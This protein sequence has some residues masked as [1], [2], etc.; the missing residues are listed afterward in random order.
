MHT[1]DKLLYE[2]ME[3]WDQSLQTGQRNLAQAI[4]DFFPTGVKSALDVGCGDGKLTESIIAATKCPIVGLDFSQE[5]LSR[6]SFKTIQ[7]DATKLPFNDG[8][9]DLVLT[10][11]V[12]E[13]LPQAMEEIVWEQLFR[14]AKKWVLVAVPFREELLEATTKCHHCAHQYHVNW[15]LRSYDWPE[16]LSRC[17]DSFEVDKIILTGEAWSP[18]HALETQLRRE[19]LDEWSGWCN[20]VCPHCES[21]GSN[22]DTP[23]ALPPLIASALGNAIYTNRLTK[24]DIRSHSEILVVYRHKTIGEMKNPPLPEA[25]VIA[26]KTNEIILDKTAVETTLIPYPAVAR[27][28]H[29]ATGGFILQFP[30]YYA[31]SDSLIIETTQQNQQIHLSV[32]DSKG[33]LFNDKLSMDSKTQYRLSLSRETVCSYYGVLHR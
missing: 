13:H 9:V 1:Q 21:P 27:A 14:V 31:S 23:K 16:L 33:S 15:H 26:S 8:E 5:A 30:T 11:D 20:A 17:P 29:A 19:V 25:H 7:G 24:P 2:S 6:C 10:T 12:L 18:Y 22:P 3:V 4:I 32:E 28:V